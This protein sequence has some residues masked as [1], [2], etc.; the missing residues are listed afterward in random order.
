MKKIILIFIS[1]IL[2]VSVACKNDN[3][4]PKTTTS[5]VI[6]TEKPS[7]PTA[8]I[9]QEP[10]PE[11]TNVP[12]A[13]IEPGKGTYAEGI[14]DETTGVKYSF[15]PSDG[16]ADHKMLT[17]SIALQFFSTASFNKIEVECPSY[18]NNEGTFVF[19]LYKWQGHLQ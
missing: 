13:T 11:P 12:V 5:P 14:K 10:T 6:R 18:S 15:R 4:T 8:K 16:R 17:Q 1:F 19:E 9:T 7:T 3:T 2:I